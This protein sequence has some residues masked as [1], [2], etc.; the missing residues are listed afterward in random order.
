MTNFVKYK[1]LQGFPLKKQL[2]G[3]F[4]PGVGVGTGHTTGSFP[5]KE[6]WLGRWQRTYRRR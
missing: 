6:A 4:H 5:C 2:P 1:V 3:L